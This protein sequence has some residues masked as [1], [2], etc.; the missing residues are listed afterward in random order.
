MHHTVRKT[1][2]IGVLALAVVGTALSSTPLASAAVSASSPD[3]FP[4]TVTIGGAKVTVKRKPVRI[5]S[6]SPSSTEILFDIGA[7]KQVKAVDELSNFPANTPRTKLSGFQPNVEAIVGFKPD[8]VVMSQADKVTDA[9][10]ALKIPVVV[11]LAAATIDDTYTQMSDLGRLTG[12]SRAAAKSVARLRLRIDQ[13]IASVPK[14]AVPLS[15]YHELDDTLYSVTSTSFVGDVYRKLGL[16]NVA[17]AAPG[18]DT[19]YPQLSAEFLLKAN[20]DLI[21]LA[22]TKCCAQS[23]ATVGKRP[24]WVNLAAV[25]HGNVVELD[26]DVASRW[27][28]RVAVFFETVAAALKKYVPAAAQSAA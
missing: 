8:L 11:H 24:G 20:P 23:A 6:I 18:A 12:N 19:G 14:A 27:G 13:A 10:R 3:K 1:L 5:V 15:F 26:D 17:D 7:G 2:S 9:L 16:R 28:P 25:Q 21:F 22:D 4:V